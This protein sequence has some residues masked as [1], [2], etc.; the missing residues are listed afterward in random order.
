MGS[1]TGRIS[2]PDLMSHVRSIQ[3]PRRR[4]CDHHSRCQMRS[5][6]CFTSI[7]TGSRWLINRR[8]SFSESHSSSAVTPLVK[9]LTPTAPYAQLR[10][11]HGFAP[12]G[13]SPIQICETTH[14]LTCG[15]MNSLRFPRTQLRDLEASNQSYL[16]DAISTKASLWRG[17]DRVPASHRCATPNAYVSLRGC[18]DNRGSDR[19]KVGPTRNRP[20]PPRVSAF[21]VHELD[22]TY[23][24]RA[25]RR[26]SARCRAQSSPRCSRRRSGEGITCRRD[27][28]HE[29][30]RQGH[31]GRLPMGHLAARRGGQACRSASVSLKSGH[32]SSGAGAHSRLVV[33]R[34]MQLFVQPLLGSQGFCRALRLRLRCDVV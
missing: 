1:P 30:S 14:P 22:F 19:P 15:P 10:I 4:R 3:V 11:I 5:L 9:H 13:L 8:I 23:A 34:G 7:T 18:S 29:S 25:E 24:K 32:V 31:G 20:T 2:D 33:L 16:L 12:F 28:F 6:L 17:H 21:K 26:R 27:G